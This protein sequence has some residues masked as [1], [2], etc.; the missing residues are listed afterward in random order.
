MERF[1]P[2]GCRLYLTAEEREA[3]VEAANGTERKVRT[4]CL[5]L[6]YTGCRISEALALTPKRLNFSGRA[7]VYPNILSMAALRLVRL[8]QKRSLAQSGLC[9]KLSI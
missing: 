5:V 1:D 6:A 9:S 4:F 2:R 8:L 3:F 7:I